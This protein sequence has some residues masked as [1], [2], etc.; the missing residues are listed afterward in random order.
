MESR[1]MV[2][3][4]L[5]AGSNGETDIEN[6]FMNSGRGEE[7]V[8]CIESHMET[9]ITICKID[10]QQEFAIWFRELKYWLCINREGCDGKGERRKG[11]YA[12][13]WLI[14]VAVWQKTTKFCKAIIL[15]LK[16]KIFLKVKFQC[17]YIKSYG[18]VVQFLSCPHYKSKFCFMELEAQT[19]HSFPACKSLSPSMLAPICSQVQGKGWVYRHEIVLYIFQDLEFFILALVGMKK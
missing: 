17:P 11:I 10:S 3:I 12:Y 18:W 2:P 9:Y 19:Q 8:G 4:N 14:H 13:L 7:R 15:Q 5:F 16:N 1:K 6:R